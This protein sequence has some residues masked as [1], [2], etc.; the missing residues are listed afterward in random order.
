MGQI[1]Q[2]RDFLQNGFHLSSPTE[3]GDSEIETRFPQDVTAKVHGERIAPEDVLTKILGDFEARNVA[4][5]N[6]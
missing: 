2:P 1:S 3:A 6:S 4:V 5:N